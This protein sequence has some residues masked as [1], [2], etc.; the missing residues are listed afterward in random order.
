MSG[1][2]GAGGWHRFDGRD[3]ETRDRANHCK[4]SGGA[5][6]LDLGPRLRDGLAM[7]WHGAA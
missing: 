2:S 3:E 6:L 5:L 4:K 7:G 1:S